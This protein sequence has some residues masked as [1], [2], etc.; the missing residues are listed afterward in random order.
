MAVTAYKFAGAVEDI[1]TVWDNDDNIKAADGNC[2]TTPINKNGGLSGVLR[3]TSFGFSSSD[4]PSDATLNGIEV[5]INR[6]C[7]YTDAV[8]DSELYLIYSSSPISSNFASAT[9]WPTSLGEVIYGSSSNMLGATSLTWSQLTNTGFGATIK[10][11][12][13]YSSNDVASVDYLKI[14]VW[15]NEAGGGVVIPVFMYHY[16]HH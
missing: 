5:A 16:M 1:S 11:V 10:L 8:S 13:S 7:I 2:T 9:K 14:R 4:L 12:N 15:Y 6:K 3:L